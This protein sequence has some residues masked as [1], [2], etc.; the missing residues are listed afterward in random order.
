MRR[1][2][3]LAKRIL[4]KIGVSEETLEWE[5]DS[6]TE[7]IEIELQG[8]AIDGVDFIGR[9]EFVVR[10]PVDQVE[11]Y[12][13]FLVEA[14]DEEDAKTRWLQEG[15]IPLNEEIEVIGLNQEPEVLKA[16]P[17]WKGE[18]DQAPA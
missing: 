6:V 11:G 14:S 13:D 17:F 7:I 3:Q 12:Q 5:L 1:T 18:D 2:K 15:G 8:A 16:W 4:E 9:Q 10:V